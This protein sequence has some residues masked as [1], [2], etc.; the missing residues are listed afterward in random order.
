MD[1]WDFNATEVNSPVL[2]GSRRG[3]S[4]SVS[5]SGSFDIGSDNHHESARPDVHPRFELPSR[6]HD[7]KEE[8]TANVQP[9]IACPLSYPTPPNLQNLQP[10]K[11]VDHDHH[12]L[13]GPLSSSCESS[14]SA[15]CRTGYETVP[16][17]DSAC[18]K[19]PPAYRPSSPGV[20]M[21][22]FAPRSVPAPI[23]IPRPRTSYFRKSSFSSSADDAHPV[24][25]SLPLNSPGLWQR[26]TG[27]TPR[28][29]TD[30]ELPVREK[31]ISGL[32]RI[33]SRR[34]STSLSQRPVVS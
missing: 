33:L 32:S 12:F 34:S 15:K 1:S 21:S 18:S 28:N 24:P 2:S 8:P 14:E 23:P 10:E 3:G 5:R 16:R 7:I 29:A 30:D 9:I 20:R 19:I 31:K 26:L 27:T 6:T 25:T 4:G 13:P 22:Q 11:A 17:L